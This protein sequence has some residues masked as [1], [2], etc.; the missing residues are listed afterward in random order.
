MSKVMS[1]SN[2]ILR[3]LQ[4][5][6]TLR[7]LVP[8]CVLACFFRYLIRSFLLSTLRIYF[9]TYSHSVS[10]SLPSFVLAGVIVSCRALTS[11]P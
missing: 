1:S 5:E 9:V 8:C 3:R 2:Q 10:L 7:I 4:R 6:L 11:L